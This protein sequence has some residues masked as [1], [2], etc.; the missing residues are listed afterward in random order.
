SELLVHDEKNPDPSYSFL[1]SALESP[2]HP[3]PLG[4]F[5]A[6]ERPSFDQLVHSQIAEAKKKMGE[7]DLKKLL[8][9]ETWTVK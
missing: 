5:R 3:V 2:Q 8:Y 7:G 6:I 4:I 1:L 9:S